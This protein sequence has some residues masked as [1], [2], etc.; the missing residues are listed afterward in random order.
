MSGNGR[1]AVTGQGGDLREP[2]PA[3]VWWGVGLAGVRGAPAEAVLGAAVWAVPDAGTVSLAGDV[4]MVVG[5]G[6]GVGGPGAGEGFGVHLLEF[7]L[8]QVYLSRVSRAPARAGV[9]NLACRSRTPK[10]RKPPKKSGGPPFYPRFNP[11]G[12]SQSSPSTKP[13]VWGE[14]SEAPSSPG[15]PGG[16][17]QGPCLL[18][19]HRIHGHSR[20]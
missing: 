10:K 2:P 20:P 8:G 5:L 9:G 16:E 1:L 6:A 13:H 4:G 12:F 19:V 7:M 15:V 18:A 3:S 14:R 17:L 11:K